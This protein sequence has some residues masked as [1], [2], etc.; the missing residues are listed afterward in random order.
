MSR[1]TKTK[2]ISPVNFS[3]AAR[4]LTGAMQA[5]PLL[6]REMPELDSVRGIAIIGVVFLHG[7]RTGRDITIFPPI[8]RHILSLIGLGQFGVT[9]FFVLSGFL[10]TGL[11]FDTRERPD[12]Y[13]RFYIRR[14]LRILPLYYVILAILAVTRVASRSFLLISLLYSANLSQIFGVKMSYVVLWSLG[15]EEHFYLAW[16]TAVRRISPRKL[17]C[18]TA[19]IIA[20]VPIFRLLCYLHSVKTGFMDSDCAYYTWNAT[21]G[22]ACGALLSLLLREFNLGRRQ[23]LMASLAL[24]LLAALVAV[25]GLPL[26]ILTRR[27]AVGAALQTVPPNFFSTGL[28]GVFLLAGTSKWKRLVTPWILR[29]FGRISYGLYLIHPLCFM[30][31]SPLLRRVAPGTFAGLSPWSDSWL[32]FVPCVCVAVAISYLSR[33]FFEE[34]FLQLKERL[35]G[36]TSSVG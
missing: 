35:S 32:M 36:S 8:Q 29:F 20:V 28:L 10:I 33:R 1:E 27:T 34:P 22:L 24:F 15:V 26:G 9:L 25:A 4:T 19:S 31:V 13:K 11:L 12:Y 30:W 21:D 7:L 3:V 14:A 6:R 18:I 5:A 17:I 23:L 2:L 16:P